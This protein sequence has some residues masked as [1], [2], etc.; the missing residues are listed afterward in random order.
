M[1]PNILG[2]TASLSLLNTVKPVHELDF[3]EEV[4]W[5]KRH[6]GSYKRF[7]NRGFRY[8]PPN[9]PHFESGH[10]QSLLVKAEAKRIRKMKD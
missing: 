2:L 7:V 8:S 6:Y 9:K 5:D 4:E 1:K 3:D 10:A